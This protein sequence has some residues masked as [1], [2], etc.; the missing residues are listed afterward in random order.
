MGDFKVI[1]WNM[2]GL[3]LKGDENRK[4]E[5]L[6]SLIHACLD[7]PD[8]PQ[9]PVLFLQEAGNLVRLLEHLIYGVQQDL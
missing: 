4:V 7:D 5:L 6:Y 8:R 3:S 1:T 2:R 9:Y